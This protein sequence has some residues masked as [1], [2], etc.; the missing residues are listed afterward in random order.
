M[1]NSNR[2][3]TFADEQTLQKYHVDS[4]AVETSYRSGSELSRCLSQLGSE[5]L[6]GHLEPLVLSLDAETGSC[7]CPLSLRIAAPRG[8]FVEDIN[9]EVLQP[10][11]YPHRLVRIAAHLPVEYRVR[12]NRPIGVLRS[13]AF[14]GTC[15]SQPRSTFLQVRPSHACI[16]L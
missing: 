1:A 14:G 7:E 16:P 11:S 13:S 2:S 3:N 12:W 5:L 10:L 15:V 6:R 4:S 8:L 9:F